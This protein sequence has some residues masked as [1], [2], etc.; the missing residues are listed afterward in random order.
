MLKPVSCGSQQTVE[1]SWRDRNT[2]PPSLPPAKPV[3]RSRNNRTRQGTTVWF[4]TGKGVHQ[5][6]ILSL[7]LFNFMPSTSCELPGGMNH[8][9]ESRLL[10]EI[11]TNNL[12]YAHDTSQMAGNKEELK[13]P[14]MRVW[15]W[16]KRVKKIAY[17][18]IIKNEDHACGP[19]TSWQIGGE[20]VE[21]VTNFI[22]LGSK[23]TADSNWSHK[24]K[25][26]LLLGR[27]AKT[28]QGHTLKSRDIT[29][30]T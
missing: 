10:G 16:K 21:T 24:I 26:C 14:L 5:G 6:C 28:I 1:N 13:S 23:D 20:K 3:C 4:Q 7:C 11:S 29:L 17:N 25:R 30:L 12:W 8:K 19:I 18:S 2:R 9:L 27:K 15:E 22:F